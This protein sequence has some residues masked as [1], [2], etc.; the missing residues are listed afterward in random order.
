MRHTGLNLFIMLLIFLAHTASASFIR[1]D[2]SVATDIGKNNSLGLKISVSNKGDEPAHAVQAEIVIGNEVYFSHKQPTLEVARTLHF[3]QSYPGKN[4]KQ[5]VYPVIV[6]IHYSDANGYPFSALLCRTFSHH[7]NAPVTEIFGEMAP[8][9]LSEK[10]KIRLTL[11]NTGKSEIQTSTTLITPKE[12]KI[13][14]E[15]QQTVVLPKALKK[16][17]FAIE[18]FS[19][20]TG[21]QYQI[22]AISEYEKNGIHQTSIT[23]GTIMVVASK[24]IIGLEYRTLILILILLAVVFFAAQFKKKKKTS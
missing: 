16:L 14:R 19:A 24:K 5:G 2:T 7:Q 13:S 9:T 1:L 3:N 20:L 10:G 8:V 12:F 6:I 4:E 11:K 22:Y 15:K 18:N 17:S 21:S 23:P